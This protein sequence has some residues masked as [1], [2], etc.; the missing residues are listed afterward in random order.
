MILLQAFNSNIVKEFLERED[1]ATM[2]QLDFTRRVGSVL[3]RVADD[4]SKLPRKSIKDSLQL[5]Y[6]EW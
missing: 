1:V 5:K 6:L 2:P 3:A 4:E